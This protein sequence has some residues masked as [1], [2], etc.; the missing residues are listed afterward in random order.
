MLQ[1][2]QIADELSGIVTSNSKRQE[3]EIIVKKVS[4]KR[5]T[6]SLTNRLRNQIG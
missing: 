1:F 3:L 6:T 2:S 5:K 4:K